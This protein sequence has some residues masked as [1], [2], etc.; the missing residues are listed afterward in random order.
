MHVLSVALCACGL[1]APVL[2]ARAQQAPLRVTPAQFRSLAWLE[3]RWRGQTSA[4][5]SFYESY[6]FLDDSTLASR[7]FPD[8]T[9]R[10]PSDSSQIRLRGSELVSQTGVKRWVASVLDTSRVHF[11]P[12]G[13]ARNTFTWRRESAD[14]WTATLRWPAKVG[15][16]TRTVVYRMQR[17]GARAAAAPSP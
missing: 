8:S 7:T 9:F 13:G 5:K 15:R 3:G 17:V 16:R 11:V 4:G 2:A 1:V 6:A 14:V 12:A 10:T